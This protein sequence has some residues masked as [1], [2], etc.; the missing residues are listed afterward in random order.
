MVSE[1]LYSDY[2]DTLLSEQGKVKR[3]CVIQFL[4]CLNLPCLILTNIGKEKRSLLLG[5]EN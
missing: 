4:L 3:I 5:V 1:L 2:Q